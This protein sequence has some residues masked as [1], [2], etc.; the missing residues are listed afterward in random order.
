MSTEVPPPGYLAEDAPLTEGK[1]LSCPHN[2]CDGMTFDTANQ[3]HLH[4]AD[5]HYGPYTCECGQ[6]YAARPALL[7]HGKRTGHVEK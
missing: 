5:W 2:S 7:R 4:E 6:K 3:A 1:R